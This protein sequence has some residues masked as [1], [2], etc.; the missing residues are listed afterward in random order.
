M[1]RVAVSVPLPSTK[2]VCVHYWKID[3][4]GP[5]KHVLR[6]ICRLCEVERNDFTP[7]FAEGREWNSQAEVEASKLWKQAAEARLLAGEDP[8]DIAKALGRHPQ[9]IQ[10]VKQHLVAM[11]RMDTSQ[12]E[13]I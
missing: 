1:S 12:G 11:G 6:G 5:G 7:Y 13:G 10:K 8:G 9:T 4:P 3:S 2:A